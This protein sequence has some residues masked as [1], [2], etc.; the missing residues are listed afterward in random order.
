[1]VRS[2]GRIQNPALDLWDVVIEV[3]N[4]SNNRKSSAQEAAGN[5]LHILNTKLTKKGNQNVDQLSNPDHVA[6]NASSSQGESQLYI[7]EDNEATIK[8][9]IKAEVQQ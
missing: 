9:I 2:S 3:L 7:F 5:S 6:T 8:M 1:M 4:S